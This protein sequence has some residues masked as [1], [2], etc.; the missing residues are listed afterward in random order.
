MEKECQEVLDGEQ[1][2]EGDAKR[3]FL[4]R[5]ADEA[6]EKHGQCVTASK[7]M[8]ECGRAA[9]QCL[10]AAKKITGHRT[11]WTKWRNKHF[12]GSNR[13][14]QI[15]M[16]VS[17]NWNHPRIEQARATGIVIDSI[18]GFL[19]ILR[20]KPAPGKSQESTIK[21]II[22][23]LS[24]QLK[25]LDPAELEILEDYF[26][27]CWKQLELRLQQNVRILVDDDYY[28]D[29]PSEAETREIRTRG[30]RRR[31][32]TASGISGSKSA[33]TTM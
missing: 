24:E 11:K 31:A 1:R 3:V 25:Q 16:Q 22:Q 7:S 13:T 6:N 29:R 26:E 20:P 21:R 18:E 4:S 10:R 12:N 32:Q 15:Y 17:R 2:Y 14:A 19:R 33:L 30:R 9:G 23:Q 8:L 27:F 28:G 5:V